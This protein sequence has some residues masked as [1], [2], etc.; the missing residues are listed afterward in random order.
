MKRAAG[1]GS[2]V[3]RRDGRWQASIR[4]GGVRKT[5]YGRTRK[6]AAEKLEAIKIEAHMHGVIANP[7][8]KTVADMFRAHIEANIPKWKPRTLHDWQVTIERYFAGLRDMPLAKLEPSDIQKSFSEFVLAGKHKT[9]LR[10]YRTIS[11]ACKTAVKYGWLSHNPCDKVEPPRYKP[12]RRE[13]WN[14]T[15]LRIFLDGARGHRMFP[16]WLTAICTGA[17]IG[18]LLALEWSDIAADL[19]AIRINKSAQRIGGKWVVGEPKTASGNRI[20]PVPNA[21]IE[22]IRFTKQNFPPSSRVFPYS[23]GH[24]GREL[25]KECQR[26]GLPPITMHGLRHLHGSLLLSEGLPITEVSERL[27]HASP[28]ITM[29]VYAHALRQ[30]RAVEVMEKV[31]E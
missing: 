2:I 21:V 7:K 16:L 3:M 14:T 10:I 1:E 26:L 6:E 23:P 11:A 20:V 9:A 17:R 31:L 22:A 5:V 30:D 18:E 19:C 4:V 25:R 29:Q 24:I 12:E 28:A 8:G 27:G 13:V 15:Q